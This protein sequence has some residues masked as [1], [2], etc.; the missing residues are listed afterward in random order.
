MK[1]QESPEQTMKTNI[2]MIFTYWNEQKF[3]EKLPEVIDL[4]KNN[5]ELSMVKGEVYD[6]R[7]PQVIGMGNLVKEV[8]LLECMILNKDIAGYENFKKDFEDIFDL[9]KLNFDQ[10]LGLLRFVSCYNN[11]YTSI[12]QGSATNKAFFGH[13]EVIKFLIEG[14]GGIEEI[15][16]K[17]ILA[18]LMNRFLE[19]QLNESDYSSLKEILKLNQINTID[20]FAE[21]HI[22]LISGRGS[23]AEM[24]AEFNFIKNMARLTGASITIIGD[25]ENGVE[26]IGT[27][28]KAIKN[29]DDNDTSKKNVVFLIGHGLNGGFNHEFVLNNDIN[30][31]KTV[32][33]IELIIS[34]FSAKN[35]QF[36]TTTCYG[37]K[38]IRDF[39]N[40]FDKPDA[41]VKICA[42]TYDP[43][44]WCDINATFMSILTK[45]VKKPELSVENF[46]DTFK[47][48]AISK[49]NSEPEVYDNINMRDYVKE[50]EVIGI[51]T[52]ITEN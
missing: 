36:I 29:I 42:L 20:K 51:P 21:Y 23:D 9:S 46:I 30:K 39:K 28:E 4:I 11:I 14:L 35:L 45:E 22:T 10:K 27:I 24:L 48:V 52:D 16:D 26:N 3:R 12:P 2:Q 40:K 19:Q 1:N 44:K 38:A 50:V 8:T 18:S 49:Y 43:V 41:K 33:L 13:F 32:S 17:G 25:C 37:N 6:L 31:Q 34:S 5:P 15:K 7:I 47:N